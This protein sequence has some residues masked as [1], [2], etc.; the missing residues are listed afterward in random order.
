MN[1]SSRHKYNLISHLRSASNKKQFWNRINKSGI[2]LNT[3]TD[4]FK[5]KFSQKETN[6]DNILKAKHD[7]EA[8]YNDLK[9]NILSNFTCSVFQ[10]RKYVAKLKTGCS[11]GIDGIVSEHIKSA[12]DTDL[13]IVLCS[14]IT[15]CFR[16]GIVPDSFCRGILIPLLKKPQAD[17]AIARN[18]RPV[19]LSTVF[20]KIAE[21]CVLDQCS[22]HE[23]SDLQFGFTD[24]RGASMAVSL[25][26]DVTTCCVDRG[27]P[28]FTCSLNAEPPFNLLP[29]PMLFNKLTNIV[30]DDGDYCTF[31]I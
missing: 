19:I 28:V 27:S 20:S 10:M 17:N 29:H 21:M 2:T 12:S 8:K 24:G 15:V 4:H 23:F 30:P 14:L 25:A 7:V 6:V 13:I 26:E 3:L 16:A 9:D 31:G 11:S 22:E 18:Y 1:K 5:N